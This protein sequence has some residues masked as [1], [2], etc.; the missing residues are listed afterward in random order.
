M[1]IDREDIMNDRYGPASSHVYNVFSDNDHV[2]GF[3]EEWQAL[4][5][6]D[7]LLAHCLKTSNPEDEA[8]YTLKVT[9]DSGVGI[10]DGEV[11]QQ[12]NVEPNKE[13]TFSRPKFKREDRPVWRTSMR[14]MNQNRR[15]V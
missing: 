6:L 11:V 2:R 9:Y 13:P 3:D 4:Q 14:A 7:E 5:Y 10:G 12:V 1:S 15:K 8:S